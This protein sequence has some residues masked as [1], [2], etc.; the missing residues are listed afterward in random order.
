MDLVVLAGR[1]VQVLSEFCRPAD[2]LVLGQHRRGRYLPPTLGPIIS[3][4]LHR[5]QCAVA[6]VA[7]MVLAKDFGA[8]TAARRAK[9][10]RPQPSGLILY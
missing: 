4:A 5:T 2:L 7:D 1:P 3:G 10:E 6:V 9:D 8:E